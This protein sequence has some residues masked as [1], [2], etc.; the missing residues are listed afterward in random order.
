MNRT[1]PKQLN[2]FARAYPFGR[3][4]YRLIAEQI[5][6]GAIKL[7]PVAGDAVEQV[8][9]GVKDAISDAEL[10]KIVDNIYT[11]VKARAGGAHDF[12]D[13][14]IEQITAVLLDKPRIQQAVA[15]LQSVSASTRRSLTR[16]LLEAQQE[17]R[18]TR[19]TVE[20]FQGAVLELRSIL[21]TVQQ[22]LQRKQAS[23]HDKFSRLRDQ[24]DRIEQALHTDVRAGRTSLEQIYQ[25]L[26]RLDTGTL[27]A[28]GQSIETATYLSARDLNIRLTVDLSEIWGYA[29]APFRSDP[30]DAFDVFVFRRRTE[31]LYLLPGTVSEL[32]RHMH[33]LHTN[34]LD[35]GRARRRAEQTLSRF[36]KMTKVGW[37]EFVSTASAPDAYA[38][39]LV[40]TAASR[41]SSPLSRM[42]QL[43]E[44]GSFSPWPDTL[45]WGSE[46]EEARR[47]I[48]ERLHRYR[49][50]KPVSN[51]VDAINLAQIAALNSTAPEQHMR[52]G[53]LSRSPLL[54]RVAQQLLSSRRMPALGVGQ[55]CLVVD[56]YSWAIQTY[57][58]DLDLTPCRAPL[59]RD[60]RS[61]QSLAHLIRDV[62]QWLEDPR[63]DAVDVLVQSMKKCR[64][65]LV[66]VSNVLGPFHADVVD[67][68]VSDFSRCIGDRGSAMW[69]ARFNEAREEVLNILND[70]LA[71]LE[72]L[73]D[74]Y[75]PFWELAESLPPAS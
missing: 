3:Q 49:P 23:E 50:G 68:E 59:L 5:L 55:S 7:I 71:W 29:F 60:S 65:A 6:R 28:A 9:F 64:S 32:L 67:E 53:H 56:P 2:G 36:E 15:E 13:A 48:L 26:S 22:G 45:S 17:S 24:L 69:E 10:R 4:L 75:Q 57:L 25:G 20:G 41:L 52:T 21:D 42:L 61:I 30:A 47:V 51:S 19:E 74:A 14:Q 38:L 8:T 63:D 12:S 37:T 1:R 18:A 62:G 54:R 70:L 35:Y 27:M 16:L 73:R 58:S 39:H 11:E 66:E 31:P 34:L 72:P 43:L 33:R 40:G 46:I 44:G